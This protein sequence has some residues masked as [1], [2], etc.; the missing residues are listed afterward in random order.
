MCI[1]QTSQ[2]TYNAG[3][4]AELEARNNPEKINE[5]S[6]PQK[7]GIHLIVSPPHALHLRLCLRLFTDE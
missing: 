4:R 1:S 3:K 7:E 2:I 5:C 6:S